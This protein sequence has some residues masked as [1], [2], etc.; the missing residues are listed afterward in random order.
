MYIPGPAA[1]SGAASELALSDRKGELE[2]LKL[3]AAGFET[4][5]VSPDG[6]RVVFGLGDTIYTYNLSGTAGMQ[7][8]TFGGKNRF[9]I[10]SADGR[11]IAFQSD[12]EG[13][14]AVFWQLAN[15]SGTAERLTKPEQ[16]EAH[17]P[18]SWAP[19]DSCSM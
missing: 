12:R 5:R 6:Q 19:I 14:L 2:R 3:A 17:V 9:P 11:H 7:R 4:P 8:L 13:D 18:L 15:G 1:G 16:G 10:W